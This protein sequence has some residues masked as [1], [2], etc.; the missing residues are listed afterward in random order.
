LSPEKK[1]KID[2]KKKITNRGELEK[3]TLIERGGGPNQP[4]SKL[5][6]QGGLATVKEAKDNA[7]L[8]R[9]VFVQ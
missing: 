3:H 6:S 1:I 2:Y 5:T 8:L 7:V 4:L 9:N